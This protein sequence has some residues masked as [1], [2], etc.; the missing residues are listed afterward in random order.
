M[1]VKRRFL[2][3][4][5]AGLLVSACLASCNPP[6][7]INVACDVADL[8]DAIH[9][10]NANSDTTKLILDANCIYTFLNFDN[11][12][13]GNGANAL[14]V[15]T[16]DIIIEGNRSTLLRS[17]SLHFRFFFITGTGSLRLEQIA[18]E[19]G[20]VPLLSP[21]PPIQINHYTPLLWSAPLCL[22]FLFNTG[23]RSLTLEENT[24]SND[25]DLTVLNDQP[26]SG[27]GAIFNDGGSLAALNT[28][29]RNNQAIL[30][31]AIYNTGTLVL[32]DKTDFD[33]NHSDYGGAILND[34]NTGIPA[35]LE[36][37]RFL[38]NQANYFGGAIYNASSET[39]FT[40][41]EVTFMGNSCHEGGGAIYNL[42][43]DLSI[44]SS[45]FLE[46]EVGPSLNAA[47]GNGGA[48]FSQGGQIS[49][50]GSEFNLNRADLAGG[51]IYAG[52][53]SN[54]SLRGATL[55]RNR[56]CDGGGALYALGAS[57]VFE[58]TF[59]L[60]MVSDVAAIGGVSSSGCP[61][62]HGGA[63]FNEG[64]LNLNSSLV[65]GNFAYEDGDGV[66]NAGDMTVVNTT[67]HENGY[68]DPEAI[69]NAG[70]AA[71][72][73][74]TIVRGKLTNIGNMSVKNIIV[75]GYDYLDDCVNSGTL[76]AVHENI[77]IDPSC[78]FS[79]I[80]TS[81]ALLS[82]DHDLSDN[83]GPTLTNFIDWN[84]VA[85]NLA[86]C[87]T[88]AGDPVTEDQRG[89][90]RP[91]PSGSTCDIGAF[92]V[93]TEGGMTSPGGD[94][95]EA[96]PEPTLP[97]P[98]PTTTPTPEPVR[99]MAFAPQNT[100]CREGDN[101]VYSAAG[102]LLEGESAEVIG[103]NQEGTWLVINNP[104]WDGICWILRSLVETEGDVDDIEVL[105]P[106]PLPTPTYTPVPGCLVQQERGGEPICVV[107]CPDD[108]SPGTPCTP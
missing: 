25:Y 48:I 101:A 43:G 85:V 77:A 42:S 98:R 74:S 46:N 100:T 39:G 84:S 99:P 40:F 23:N 54:L 104:D 73:L 21:T 7:E 76:N 91:Q 2:P 50:H 92:E 5:A 75:S 80:L 63:I 4:L 44:S 15:I 51:A 47:S 45:T 70:D 62:P 38:N 59:Q 66:Y 49:I 97:L 14:P 83:G 33:D 95:V 94:H 72:S 29:F 57:D 28:V 79:I 90:S 3:L 8:I 78:P 36:E 18:L 26:V 108:A 82:M 89:V 34:G 19:N 58:T 9:S 86:S 106:P 32:G 69:Y 53:D 81:R 68:T 27:G 11:E 102:Y 1:C 13:G 61:D 93:E 56:S 105:I 17:S 71:L 55:E 20:S 41:S 88:V 6:A 64:T 107:P 31:G 103:R 10:A 12:D 16:T 65:A 30:G 22:R 96:S 52:P 24:L 37:V 60:N 35:V 87:T 67:F